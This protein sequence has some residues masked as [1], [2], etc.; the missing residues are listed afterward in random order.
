MRHI[1]IT[2]V[3][4]GLLF[5]GYFGYKLI[6]QIPENNVEDAKLFSQMLGRQ[7]KSLLNEKNKFE[8]VRK[9]PDWVFLSPYAEAEEWPLRF[10]KAQSNF[11]KAEILNNDVI[12]PIIKRDHK[13][14]VQ[15][16]SDA[17]KQAVDL[18]NS[19]KIESNYSIK[20]AGFLVEAK[21][22]KETYYE[23]AKVLIG[24][25]NESAEF[26][27]T[28]VESS[29]SSH[30][31]KRED[32]TGKAIKIGAIIERRD[33]LFTAMQ[34]EYLSPATNYAVYADSYEGLKVTHEEL[35]EKIYINVGLLGQLD[36]SYVKVLSDQKID[37]FVVIGRA[38]WCENEGCYNGSEMRYPAAK[39]DEDSFDFFDTTTVSVIAKHTQ[40]WGAAKFSLL[41][42]KQ[43]WEALGISYK[44]RWNNREPYA[45]YW[46]DSTKTKAYHKYTIIEGGEVKEEGWTLVSDALFWKNYENLG[47]A[48]ETKPLG[49]YESEL[50]DTA[51]P[52][53][54]AVIAEPAIVNG[55][56][57]GSNEYG[58][59]RHSGGGSFFHYYG[60]YR[61]FSNFGYPRRYSY[62]D[63]NH[64]NSYGRSG[65]YYG[66]DEQYG[67]Y[68]SGT[69][70]G[71]R[72][73][74]S[75]FAKRNPSALR[76]A[77]T[78]RTS[79][80]SNSVRGAGPLGRGKGPSGSGK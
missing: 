62:A 35:L 8:A 29:I 25:G 37:Y 39:V 58:E 14:D 68:G 51:E 4:L 3:V 59:W 18:V 31:N 72:Y 64:Y 49:F 63:W 76:E 79:K 66:R 7:E 61:V 17:V 46:V 12:I 26:L 41:I 40:G 20:R 50:I 43:R 2:V 45:E 65:S 13:D 9:S 57:T 33:S 74:N 71:A 22:N 11:S 16:L 24:Q 42:P 54:M 56:P 75:S 5:V 44:Y 55:I 15:A 6:T 19:S 60:M 73:S 28:M 67:T 80:L 52:I 53:G 27:F 21:K 70:T 10:A 78:I 34:S 23:N 36:R 77:K 48:L 47:M 1:K 38:N 32:I 30:E 69:Y